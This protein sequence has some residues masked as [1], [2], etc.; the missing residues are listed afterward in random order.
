MADISFSI[1]AT[2]L[3]FDD[4]NGAE[5]GFRGDSVDA[6]SL[7]RLVGIVMAAEPAE[8]WRYAIRTDDTSPLRAD[9]IATLASSR[10]YADWHAGQI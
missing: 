9:Q 3:A 8:R 1:P 2:L 4:Q 5:T 6:G 7:G 10:S